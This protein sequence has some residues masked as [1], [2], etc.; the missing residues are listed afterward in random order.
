[1]SEPRDDYMENYNIPAYQVRVH[2]ELA[3]VC[4]RRD[5]LEYFIGSKDYLDLDPLDKS[6]LSRQYTCMNEYID[7]LKQRIARFKS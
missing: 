3:E 7:I 2:T 5:K 1:M 4:E 6:L